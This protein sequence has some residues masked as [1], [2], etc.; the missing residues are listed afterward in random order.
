MDVQ[1]C[2]YIEKTDWIVQYKR[3]YFIVCD[4]YL[5]KAIIKIKLIHCNIYVYVEFEYLG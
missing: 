4:L 2:E 1:L 5:K 3:V